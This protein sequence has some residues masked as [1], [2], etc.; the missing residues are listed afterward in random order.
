MIS[1]L[2]IVMAVLVGTAA[3]GR[4][5]DDELGRI[6]RGER[7]TDDELQRQWDAVTAEAGSRW[8]TVRERRRERHMRR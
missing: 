1:A 7:P 4:E 8:Q 3:A 6:R 5:I 2:F